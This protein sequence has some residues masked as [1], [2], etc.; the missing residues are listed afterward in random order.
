MCDE[1]ITGNSPEKLSMNMREHF[2]YVHEMKVVDDVTRFSSG[3][4]EG[5]KVEDEVTRFSSRPSEGGKVE[6]EVT[7]FSSRP[8][9]GGKEEDE[10]TRFSSQPS[11]GD[12]P[13]SMKLI[14]VVTRF[15]R[16]PVSGKSIASETCKGPTEGKVNVNCPICGCPMYGR[17]DDDL[18]GVLRGH[19]T[20][21]HHL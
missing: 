7:R 9:E 16:D 17:D 2:S 21:D 4:S 3:P 13:E 14:Q 10:V 5:G 19:V 11:G 20:Q 1:R 6:D 12:S 15:Q 8:S 18:S